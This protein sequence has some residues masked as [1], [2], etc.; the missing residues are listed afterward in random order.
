[1]PSQSKDLSIRD[2]DLPISSVAIAGVGLIGASFG[3][4]LRDGGFTGPILGVSSR[5]ALDAAL[6]KGAITETATLEEA[7]A[8]ADVL[9]LARPV[10]RILETLAQVSSA[11]EVRITRRPILITD[12]GS[13]K[14]AIVE[15]ASRSLPPNVFLG[16]HPMAGKEVSGADA[17][18][19]HLFRGR[20][21]ILTPT[22]GFENP[23]FT[24]FRKLIMTLGAAALTLT[25]QEHDSV[26]AMTSHL[27]QLLST[28]LGLTLSAHPNPH[29]AVVHGSGLADMTRLALSSSELWQS[30]IDTNRE[31][32]LDVI[33]KFI[34]ELGKMR[35]AVEKGD[36]GASFAQASATC[37]QIRKTNQHFADCYSFFSE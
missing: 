25:P 35:Q 34:W 9:Y 8:K 28:T 11:V 18:E 23:F 30:I 1:M 36:I 21:Y 3:L 10:A 27:P 26:V 22:P 5:P 7:V 19:S 24:S 16:G 2:Q 15:K 33:D 32:I 31:H 29:F 6:R 13:T 14:E 20:P 12:A 17:A 37:L 4:A